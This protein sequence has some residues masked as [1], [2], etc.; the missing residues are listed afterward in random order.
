MQD[1]AITTLFFDFFGVVCSEVAPFWVSKYARSEEHARALYS[2]IKLADAGVI[3]DEEMYAR[4]SEETAEKPGK[5][6]G[7]W[8]ALASIDWEIVALLDLLSA[9]RRIIL[10]SNSPARFLTS[11]LLKNNLFKKFEHVLISA[12]MQL[13][14]PDRAI[15]LKACEL[16]QTKVHEVLVIDDQLANINAAESIGIRG[17]LFKSAQELRAHQLL[18]FS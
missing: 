3:S 13:A 15:Y 14:K 5:I 16:T 11:L 2:I 9:T 4:L 17:I 7:D 6:E 1:S 8:H 10:L 18:C 12:E